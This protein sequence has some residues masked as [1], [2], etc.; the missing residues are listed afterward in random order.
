MVP[1]PSIDISIAV[2]TDRGLITPIVRNANQK[3]LVA[4]SEEVPPLSLPGHRRLNSR[5]HVPPWSMLVVPKSSGGR[6]S[7]ET[8]ISGW[9]PADSPHGKGCSTQTLFMAGVARRTP[10][11]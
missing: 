9:P 6:K 11:M 1:S 10:I 2:A 3:S 7:Y 5:P 4:I 8:C